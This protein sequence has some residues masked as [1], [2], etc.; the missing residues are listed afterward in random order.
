MFAARRSQAAQGQDQAEHRRNQC[1]GRAR[2]R[3]SAPAQDK[4]DDR[5]AEAEGESSAPRGG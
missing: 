2:A 4:A 5:R 1:N 3:T